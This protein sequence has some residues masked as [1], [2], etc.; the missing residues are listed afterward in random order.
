MRSVPPASA[1][2]GYTCGLNTDFITR[3]LLDANHLDQILQ[4][5]FSF[6]VKHVGPMFYLLLVR[7][8]QCRFDLGDQSLLIAIVVKPHAT[9]FSRSRGNNRN[10]APESFHA[11]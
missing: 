1:S 10:S 9:R 7:I 5:L 6:F 2:Q 4:I 3:S 11:R 8:K